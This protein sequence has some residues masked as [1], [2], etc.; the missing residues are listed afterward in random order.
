M[1]KNSIPKLLDT[2]R[3]TLPVVAKWSGVSLWVARLWQA[4]AYQ[5]QASQ[6]ARL[7]KSAR[8][9]ATT[10]VTLAQ[11]VEG[12]GSTRS[13]RAGS[14]SRG[15]RRGRAVVPAKV[16]RSAGRRAT[17]RVRRI[18]KGTKQ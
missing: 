16:R 18:H 8:Q 6:R 15:R 11:A 1:A 12:E 10:L 14:R 3:P 7:V 17:T 2:L 5:P 4:N 9:H 13:A